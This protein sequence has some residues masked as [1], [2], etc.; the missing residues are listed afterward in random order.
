MNATSFSY[1]PNE[2]Y[3]NPLMS[4]MRNLMNVWILLAWMTADSL[5]T[6]SLSSTVSILAFQR[7]LFV[8]NFQTFEVGELKAVWWYEIYSPLQNHS[9]IDY[10]DIPR[11]GMQSED[12]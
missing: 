7:K 9:N 6:L 3:Y 2:W 4:T 8:V 12:G 10:S 5:C 11:Y 1:K